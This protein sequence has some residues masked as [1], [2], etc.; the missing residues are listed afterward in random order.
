MF[1][2]KNLSS[3]DPPASAS[4]AAAVRTVLG[5]QT[6]SFFSFPLCLMENATGFWPLDPLPRG[7]LSLQVSLAECWLL[8]VK[9][10]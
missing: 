5:S 9:R 10:I 1:K 8:K 4:H 6:S 7:I 3:N 2:K